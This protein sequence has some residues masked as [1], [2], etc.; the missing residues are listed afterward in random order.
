MPAF[1]K[2]IP[3]HMDYKGQQ[4]AERF[5]QVVIVAHGIIG[6]IIGYL[7]QQFSYTVYTLA[8]GFALCCLIILPP[9]PYFRRNNLNW[10]KPGPATAATASGSFTNRTGPSTS[11]SGLP[12]A[13][14]KKKNK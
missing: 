5:F 4:K 10:Q 1:I 11:R 13:A 3:S 7:F 6:F 14:A 12:S 2:N 8:F 9:W